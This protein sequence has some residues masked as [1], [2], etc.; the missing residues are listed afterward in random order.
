MAF[1]ADGDMMRQQLDMLIEMYE[2]YLDLF[3]KWITLYATVVGAIAL[4][5]FKQ[6][7]DGQTRRMLP[8]LI[9][10]TSLVV[11]FGCLA[12]W[13]WLRE[14]EREVVVVSN[15]LSEVRCPSFLGIRM[16]VLALIMTLCFAVANV[17]YSIFGKF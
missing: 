17:L 14:L 7:I 16:T 5:V 11:S 2:H 9:A 10:V 4:Y 15:K 3:L 12:M 8:M 1:E 13:A 6:D